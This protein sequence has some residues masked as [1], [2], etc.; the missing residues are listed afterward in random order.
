[1]NWEINLHPAVELWLL[2]LAD[3]EPDS[4]GLV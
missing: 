2:K 3:E 1:M 4:A